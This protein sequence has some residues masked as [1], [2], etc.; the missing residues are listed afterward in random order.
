GFFAELAKPLESPFGG[1]EAFMAVELVPGALAGVR[2]EVHYAPPFLGEPP[3]QRG[4]PNASPGWLRPLNLLVVDWA[5]AVC[6]LSGGAAIPAWATSGGY[7]SITR[8]P[9][10]LS[11][12]CREDAVPAGVSCERSWRCLRVA[13]TM[14]FS[15]VGVLASLT[16]PLALAGISVFAL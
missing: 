6:K 1:G 16:T 3:I 13:G 4:P 14:P 2:G 7:F 12:V 10:E 15:T 8:T 9:D 5:F 11:V